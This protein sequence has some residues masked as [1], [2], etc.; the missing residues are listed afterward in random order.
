MLYGLSQAGATCSEMEPYAFSYIDDIIIVTETFE[1]HVKWLGHIPRRI[2]EAHLTINREKSVFG[3]TEV[4]Y[5]GVLMNRDGFRLD[6]EN[7]SPIVHYPVP[8][9][10]KQLRWFLGMAS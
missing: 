10:L 8:R 7:I 2:N 9:N 6:S 3:Q 4:R 5:L 1:E